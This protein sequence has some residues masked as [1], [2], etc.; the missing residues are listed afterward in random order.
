V[1]GKLEGKV[2]IVTGASR[3][4]GNAIAY[5]LASNGAKTIINYNKNEKKAEETAATIRERGGEALSV[6]ADISVTSEVEML[7]AETIRAYGRVDIL[8]NNAGIMITKP[9]DRIAEDDFDRIMGINVKGTFFTTQ[10]AFRYMQPGGRVINISTSVVGQMFPG[11]SL[12]A[13]SK[14]AVEQL[15]RQLAKEFGKKGITINAIAPGPVNTELFAADKSQEQIDNMKK[16][17][18][19]ER[20]GEPDDISRVVL[21]LASPESQWITGQTIRVNGGFI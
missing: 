6:K 13:A 8:V 15:T 9:I 10:Q 18:A 11:Y 20:I 19:F 17:I 5:E 3:G 12:Y 16:T 1:T 7:F 14:G 21:F 2:A 4:I